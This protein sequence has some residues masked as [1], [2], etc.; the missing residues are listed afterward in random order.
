MYIIFVPRGVLL[1]LKI[2]PFHCF[3]KERS[4][5]SNYLGHFL[6]LDSVVDQYVPF[7]WYS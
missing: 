6:R 3:F 5:G 2:A 4:N 7:S 1:F